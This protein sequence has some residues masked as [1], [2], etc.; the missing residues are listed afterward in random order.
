MTVLISAL[1][2]FCAASPA[3]GIK[4]V[5]RMSKEGLKTLLDNSDVII[6]DARTPNDWEQSGI[7]IKGAHR[8]DPSSVESWEPTYPKDKTIVVYCS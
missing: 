6:L 5:P 1:V 8:V 2:L 7:K 3:L 4:D